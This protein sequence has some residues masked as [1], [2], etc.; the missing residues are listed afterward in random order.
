M[1]QRKVLRKN[2]YY[3][4]ARFNRSENSANLK[5]KIDE[6][7]RGLKT[8]GERRFNVGGKDEPCFLINTPIN[9]TKANG[10]TFGTLI[11]FTPGKDPLFLI[12]DED[13]SNFSLEKIKV[14]LTD[15]GKRREFIESIMFFCVKGNHVALL[16][17]QSLKAIHL[18][19]YLNWIFNKSGITSPDQRVTLDDSPPPRIV[20]KIKSGEG[21]REINISGFVSANNSSQLN[22]GSTQDLFKEESEEK[23]FTKFLKSFVHESSDSELDFS[24]LHNSSIRMSINL[25]YSDSANQNGQNL[26]DSMGAVFRNLEGVD[27]TL[28]LANGSTIKGSELKVHGPVSVGSYGGQLVEFEA[29]ESLREWLLKTLSDKLD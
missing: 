7:L 4:Q 11:T 22:I 23:G 27:T 18:E 2:V 5:S 17:S 8:I 1:T 24:K 29:Y 16:Q 20:E 12:D 25:K 26:M 28:E 10:F 13:A 3:K 15:D 21:V 9:E 14:R 6:A 19:Q